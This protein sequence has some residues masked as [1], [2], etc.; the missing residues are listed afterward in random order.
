V[1]AITHL[2][3]AIP[4]SSTHGIAGR[5]YRDTTCTQPSAKDRNKSKGQAAQ[6]LHKTGRPR[7]EGRA[8]ER[9]PNARTRT[10]SARGSAS[11]AS[12]IWTTEWIAA[13]ASPGLARAPALAAAVL[14]STA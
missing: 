9:L 3:E 10:K 2:N 12:S 5:R 8:V 11:V 1:V 13:T 7:D 4:R 6:T 14:G